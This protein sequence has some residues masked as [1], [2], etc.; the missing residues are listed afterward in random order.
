MAKKKSVEERLQRVE[1]LL[2]SLLLVEQYRLT[3]NSR[4]PFY[5][6]KTECGVRLL[7]HRSPSLFVV[8]DGEESYA[9]P[10]HKIQYNFKP[11]PLTVVDFDSLQLDEKYMADFRARHMASLEYFLTPEDSPWATTKEQDDVN[12]MM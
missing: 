4:V 3:F 8:S 10:P 5:Q 11:I 2:E 12:K 6:P 9:E 1:E 7:H